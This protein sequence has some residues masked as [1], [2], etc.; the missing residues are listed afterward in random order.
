MDSI[1]CV[2]IDQSLPLVLRRELGDLPKLNRRSGSGVHRHDELTF[3]CE[4][5]DGASD[6]ARSCNG[7]LRENAD[8]PALSYDVLNPVFS[9]CPEAR[10]HHDFSLREILLDLHSVL[11]AQPIDEWILHQVFDT[12]GVK[13]S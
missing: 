1:A 6:K 8:C 2:H 5:L 7:P 13:C 12:D 10:S 11:A 9:V 3:Q 4:A